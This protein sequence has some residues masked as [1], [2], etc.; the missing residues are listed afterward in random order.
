MELGEQVVTRMAALEPLRAPHTKVWEDCYRFTYPL[1]AG[2]FY[3]EMVTANDAQ[4]KKADATD[5]TTTES[6]RILA[7]Q[8]VDGMTPANALWFSLDV[9]KESDEEKRWLYNAA[10]FIWENIHN[11][12]FDSEAFESIIDAVCAGWFVLYVDE[13]KQGGYR[14][15]QWPISQCHI[16]ATDPGAPID[17]VYRKFK[18]TAAQAVTEY[19]EENVSE[20]INKAI[21]DNKPDAEFEFIHA[22]YP[23]KKHVVDA[24]LAKNL[25]IASV[26]VEAKTK[27]VAR[28]GGYHEM[29][30]IVPRMMRIPG[31][32]YAVGPVFDAL[33]DTK[34]VCEIKRLMLANL[35]IAV[36]GMYVAED[37]GVLNPLNIK[38]GPRRV[39]VA[40]SVDSIKELR[41]G[42]D[43][44][45]GFVS[46]E[47]IQAQIRKILLAD[48]LPPME[49]QPRTA[50]EI[51]ARLAHIRKMLGPM[52]GRLQS[53]YLQ[54]LV[55]RC[56]GLA[57]RAGVLGRPPET[58]AN[59]T[60]TV[61]YMSP[62]ARAQKLEE[63]AAIDQYVAGAVE[64]AQVDPTILDNVDLD[65][66]MR[67]KGEALG[68]P[69]EVI[70]DKDQVAR[71][72][73]QRA[74]QQQA[75]MAQIQ[76]QE[77]STEAG[78]AAIHKAIGA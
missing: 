62:L 56:F 66:A 2:G 69:T 58:L 65:A 38:V 27:K 34:T 35:D 71:K 72:R 59:R 13:A 73:Q 61:K 26:H 54:P 31:G 63:V 24:R 4:T 78:K 76:E 30:C 32:P 68:V 29:P 74:E 55:E 6:A 42:A 46:E 44:N 1:R 18:L 28:E 52:F 11:S 16:A 53:E 21:R 5:S 39:I 48:I 75:E 33:P 60:F 45:A 49:G 36:G 37:D 47:R 43:F 41:S 9:G 8:I 50:A 17:T 19:G 22:I 23:R 7:S 15:Q 40:N 77:L 57:Y 12:N 14:F 67:F 51:Y 10:K 20:D 3:G 64:V 70:P 25:P